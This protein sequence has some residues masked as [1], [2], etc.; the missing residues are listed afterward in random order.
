[1]AMDTSWVRFVVTSRRKW[2]QVGSPAPTQ[3]TGFEAVAVPVQVVDFDVPPTAPDV[4]VADWAAVGAA[5]PAATTAAT[6]R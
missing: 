1:M 4:G 3:A 5:S 6:A 2:S